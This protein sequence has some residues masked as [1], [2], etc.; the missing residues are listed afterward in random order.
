MALAGDF[1]RDFLKQERARKENK[2][3]FMFPAFTLVCLSSVSAA[4]P[5]PLGFERE[6]KGQ[7][8]NIHKPVLGELKRGTLLVVLYAHIQLRKMKW[9][10][11]F[12]IHL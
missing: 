12:L 8:T 4:I 1:Q 5:Y 7:K 10:S 9:C 6:N 11:R 3:A 2:I